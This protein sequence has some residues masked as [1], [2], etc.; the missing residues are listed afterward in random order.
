MMFSDPLPVSSEHMTAL[1]D[2]RD[3]VQL[4]V[5]PRVVQEAEFLLWDSFQVGRK[6]WNYL[7]DNEKD[8]WHRS[9]YIV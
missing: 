2:R 1:I 3:D 4:T 9:E 5:S 7:R 6:A 8:I